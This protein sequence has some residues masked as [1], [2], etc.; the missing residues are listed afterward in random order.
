MFS[1]LSEEYPAT[2]A[3]TTT[4]QQ[5]SRARSRAMPSIIG[6][7]LLIEGSISALGDIQLDGRV[8]GDICGAGVA[9]G[10]S[11]Q[12]YGEIV[13]DDVIVRGH[14]KG[15]I[16]ARRVLLCSTCHVE[17]DI[18]HE[19]LVIEAG[20]FFQGN[21]FHPGGL[22]ANSP[23]IADEINPTIVR[24]TSRPGARIAGQE[25][26]TALRAL[27]PPL[28]GAREARSTVRSRTLSKYL[29]LPLLSAGL[30]FAIPNDR[31]GVSA[32]ENTAIASLNRIIAGYVSLA[33]VPSNFEK[34]VQTNFGQ[35][36][37]RGDSLTRATSRLIEVSANRIEALMPRKVARRTMLAEVQPIMPKTR[38]IGV[39]QL[40]PAGQEKMPE[41][42]GLSV[43]PYDPNYHVGTGTAYLRLQYQKYVSPP[44]LATIDGGAG[45]LDDHTQKSPTFPAKTLANVNGTASVPDAGVQRSTRSSARLVEFTRPDGSPVWIDVA[46]VIS[47]R[48]TFPGEYASG[49]Q[50]VVSWGKSKQGVRESVAAAATII[51]DHGGKL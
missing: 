23:K 33:A 28:P 51:R 30:V 44:T 15:R 5:K 11:G 1:R 21:C 49:V 12:I 17:G 26:E 25:T 43:D 9:I 20:A 19:A 46:M 47:V 39:T 10:G 3:V 34:K 18:L 45:K 4:S 2:A 48:V 24:A 35:L 40:V 27:Y 38:A 37:G 8:D 13:A 7:D 31:L 6:A 41:P 50:S 29:V 36:I 16:R 42:H 32:G 14:I 22:L